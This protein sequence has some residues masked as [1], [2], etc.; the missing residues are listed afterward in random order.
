MSR[1]VFLPVGTTNSPAGASSAA[2]GLRQSRGKGEGEGEGETGQSRRVQRPALRSPDPSCAAIRLC[3]SVAHLLA[4]GSA[5]PDLLHG[6][7]SSF[8]FFLCPSMSDKLR[9]DGRV[10]I[11][12]GAG[13]QTSLGRALMRQADG[14]TRWHLPLFADPS[15][16]LLV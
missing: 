12:T 7:S 10:A 16:P 1:E 4:L 2:Q 13:G 8:P 11:V 6:P 14:G 15:L 9:F 3:V 5:S